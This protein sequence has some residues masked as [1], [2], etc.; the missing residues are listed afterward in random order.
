MRRHDGRRTALPAWSAWPRSSLWPWSRRRSPACRRP[1]NA[2]PATPNADGTQP[3]VVVEDGA[4]REVDL[5]AGQIAA[6]EADPTAAVVPRGHT[7]GP[8]LALSVPTVGA[9]TMWAQGQRGAGRVIVVIDT[10]VG[11]GFG[12]TL[13]GQACFAAKRDRNRR[14]LRSVRERPAGLRQHLLHARRVRRRRC[15]RRRGGSAVPVTVDAL[16]LRARHRGRRR[17]RSSRAHPGG[18]TRRGGSTR[19][20]RSTR[21]GPSLT[22]PT[23]CS[24]WTTY[25]CS[26]TQGCPWRR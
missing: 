7:V 4:A 3:A 23:S 8:A 25:G 5:T 6:I 24:R 9:P 1:S 22:W 10:G 13:V 20:A 17:R 19:S 26:S 12:G 21:R 11:S 18:G 16:G 2:S 14:V 15:P